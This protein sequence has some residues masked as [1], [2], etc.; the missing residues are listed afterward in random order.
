MLRGFD[1][2]KIVYRLSGST[3][4]SQKTCLKIIHKSALL[5]RMLVLFLRKFV[6]SALDNID[7]IMHARVM[8]SL[9]LCRYTVLFS[10]KF[11]TPHANK[12][13]SEQAR[14]VKQNE[15]YSPNDVCDKLYHRSLNDFY[16]ICRFR[17]FVRHHWFA[18]T[19]YS[20]WLDLQT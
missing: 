18:S 17:S 2:K 6:T 11:R 1:K 13:C 5:F 3:L 10:R 7:F 16:F 20:F 14:N 8:H 9:F 15:N 12:S 19:I 4:T